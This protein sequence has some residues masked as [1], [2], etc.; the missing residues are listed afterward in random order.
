MTLPFIYGINP[1]DFVFRSIGKTQSFLLPPSNESWTVTVSDL[2]DLVVLLEDAE[3]VR[4]G[5][6]SMFTGACD[7]R[8][9]W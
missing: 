3:P 7:D 1:S 2:E 6:L 8:R 9:S 4:G 5:G